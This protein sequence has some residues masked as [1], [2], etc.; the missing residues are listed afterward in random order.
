MK[1]GKLSCPMEQDEDLGMFWQRCASSAP[2]LASIAR[3]LL[4]VVPTEAACER[5]FST[6]SYL[7]SKMRNSLKDA[8][9]WALMNV[10]M[11]LH[12]VDEYPIGKI[13]RRE[14]FTLEGQNDVNISP[15][16]FFPGMLC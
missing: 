4:S 13:L 5:S 7:H 6:Q 3:C 10:R 8:S 11:N 9:V 15:H 14:K 16:L 2:L 12:L 1:E